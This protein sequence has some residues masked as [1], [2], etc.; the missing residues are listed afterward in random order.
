MFRHGVQHRSQDRLK[1][2]HGGCRHVA[3]GYRKVCARARRAGYRI[4]RKRVARLLRIWGFCRARRRPHPKAQGRP[5]EITKPDELWQTDLTALWCGEDG[6]AYFT[7]VLDCYDRSILGW[8]FTRRCRA[9]DVVVA[10]EHAHA[11]AYPHLVEPAE[12]G[13]VLRHDNGTQFTAGRYL[14]T[15]AVLGIKLSRTAYRHP[16]G[17]AFAEHLYRTYKEECVWPNEFASFATRRARQPGPARRR[18]GHPSLPSLRWA[19]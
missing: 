3:A 11:A 8:C 16:D 7:A 10:L 12:V 2:L 14:D 6:W 18:P 5:F 13:V 17:N 1:A 19:Y 4:N 9:L 15:A